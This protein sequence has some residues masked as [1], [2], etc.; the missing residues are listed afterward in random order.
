MLMTLNRKA[1]T[2]RQ[3]QHCPGA[4]GPPHLHEEQR[5]RAS[6]A[7]H[8]L[9]GMGGEGDEDTTCAPA[10]ETK[11]SIIGVIKQRQAFLDRGGIADKG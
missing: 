11:T 5:Q 9:G 1:R 3:G 10:G 2:A 4:E 8:Q 6:Y 7:A